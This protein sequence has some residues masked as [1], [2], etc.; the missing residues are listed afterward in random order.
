MSER[1]EIIGENSEGGIVCH[2]NLVKVQDVDCSVD[3]VWSLVG[4]LNPADRSELLR[5]LFADP[6]VHHEVETLLHTSKLIVLENKRAA[7]AALARKEDESRTAAGP[8]SVIQFSTRMYYCTESDKST[9]VDVVRLGDCTAACSISFK[10]VDGSARKGEKY[11]QTEGTLEFASGDDAKPINLKLLQ[12]DNWDATLEFSVCLSDPTGGARIGK[13][14]DNCTVKIIDDDA[15]PTNKYR[16]ELLG[17][18]CE[19]ISHWQLMFQYIKMNY[20]DP[21]VRA[22]TRK[23]F[24]ADAFHNIYFILMVFLSWYMVDQIL[25]AKAQ[26]NQ[27]D[28]LFPDKPLTTLYVITAATIVPTFVTH[29]ADYRRSFWKIGGASRKRLQANL[30]RKFL[31]YDA[32]SRAKVK[33]AELIMAM[34][35]DTADLVANGYVRFL[36]L[37]RLF[38]KLLIIVVYQVFFLFVIAKPEGAETTGPLILVPILAFP[39]LMIFFLSARGWKVAR[40]DAAVNK[41]QN[42]MVAF[43]EQTVTCYPL[44]ADYSRRGIAVKALEGR[45]N[46]LNKVIVEQNAVRVNNKYFSPWVKTLI[47]GGYMILGG[48]QVLGI[49]GSTKITLGV[50]LATYKIFSAVGNAYLEIYEGLLAMTSA[51]P[52][53][54]QITRLMNLPVDIAPRM[55]QCKKRLQEGD[56][57][58]HHE[59]ELAMKSHKD[60]TTVPADSVK[61]E[62]K[63]ASYAYIKLQVSS[64]RIS[65][66]LTRMLDAKDS[67]SLTTVPELAEAKVGIQNCSCVMDQGTMVAVIGPHS[68]GKSTFLKVLGGV[69]LPQS[70]ITFSPPWLKLLHVSAEPLFT[71][72]TL[73]ENLTFGVN[74]DDAEDGSLDR[75]VKICEM[76]LLPPA[77]IDRIKAD[78]LENWSEVLSRSQKPL[79]TIARAFIANPEILV[80]HMPT[81][82]IDG[83]VDTTVAERVGELLRAYVD[84]RGI[85]QN[86]K[87]RHLR[88][89]RT[90]IVS[91]RRLD[92][93]R[94]A[95]KVLLVKRNA[96]SEVA[97]TNVTDEML[98]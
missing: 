26:E 49:I 74:Q 71:E 12:N 14:L 85:E 35:R 61:I 24:I 19:E 62:F 82:A 56:E 59:R 77:I 80:I 66:S 54:Y 38:A 1:N 40:V 5:R 79:I 47:L 16:E 3:R 44:L 20:T 94:S 50:Y 95:D 46:H 30:L 89:P 17:Q 67:A 6:D 7:Q 70:G 51:F 81:L 76:L 42:D 48:G 88:R 53:L 60:L 10:T 90:V 13:Y 57:F 83:E 27:H 18:R 4:T 96:V 86:A 9:S 45:I 52:A 72:G 22:G 91:T 87:T 11:L 23:L 41:A 68:E 92:M 65:R 73:M 34:T 31:N 98:A 29:F 33:E 36:G 15:F 64:L 37:L 97:K 43:T 39:L 69:L 63:D 2:E 32:A 93:V 28:L 8:D 84:D 55:N 75:V 21:A 58:R 25:S 78:S